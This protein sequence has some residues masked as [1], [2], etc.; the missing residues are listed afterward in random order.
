MIWVDPYSST[1]AVMTPCAIFATTA[2]QSWSLL[3]KKVE[4]HS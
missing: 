3:M 1:Q 2:S 4:S